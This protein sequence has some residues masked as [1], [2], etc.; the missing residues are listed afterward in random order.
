MRNLGN[1]R[2]GNMR[3]EAGDMAMTNLWKVIT[4]II[5]I[6]IIKTYLRC[7]QPLAFSYFVNNYLPFNFRSVSITYLCYFPP[8]LHRYKKNLKGLYIVHPSSIVKMFWGIFRHIV[9][10]KFSKKVIYMHHLLEVNELYSV[11]RLD[12]PDD[13]ME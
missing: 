6:I 3:L 13:V 8:F 11:E 2:N 12:I 7:I 4:I 10:A 1:C 5:I 9:S